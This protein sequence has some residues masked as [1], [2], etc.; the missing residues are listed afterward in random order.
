M[1]AQEMRF[2]V[3]RSELAQ[4]R[5]RIIKAGGELV[6]PRARQTS[7]IYDDSLRSVQ[8]Q[9]ARLCLEAGKKYSISYE[10]SLSRGGVRQ[11][12]VLGATVSSMEQMKKIL[13]RIG[14]RPVSRY[15]CYQTCW[16]VGLV[17][18]TLK[19]FSFGQFLEINGDA[20]AIIRTARELGFDIKNCIN[21]SYES[22]YQSSARAT[23]TSEF[24]HA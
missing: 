9:D 3:K 13:Q 22:I 17:R 1:I 5:A 12:L 19:E 18:A 2:S 23:A 7:I 14:F 15:A 8:V 6:V 20:K 16:G 24:A 21:D 10:R 4:I 11:G